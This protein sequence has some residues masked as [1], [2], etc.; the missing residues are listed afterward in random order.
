MADRVT[1]V[2]SFAPNFHYLATNSFIQGT[3]NSVPSQTGFFSD[4]G[5]DNYASPYGRF[6]LGISSLDPSFRHLF[7][8]AYCVG[9]ILHRLV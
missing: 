8:W 9:L 2:G 6:F 4:N 3:Y 7:T 5:G 1:L